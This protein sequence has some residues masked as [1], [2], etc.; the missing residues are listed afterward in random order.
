MTKSQD[1]ENRGKCK[2]GH[3]SP[4]PN[5]AWCDLNNKRDFIK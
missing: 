5:S 2:Y 4:T 3:C 1:F